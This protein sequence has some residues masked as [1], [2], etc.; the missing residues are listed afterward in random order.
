MNCRDFERWLD[1]GM[2]DG[3]AARQH[4]DACDSCRSKLSAAEA[5][6]AALA[7]GIPSGVA[8]PAG[9]T[10]AVM[11]RVANLEAAR[12]PQRFGVVRDAFPWWVRAAAEPSTAMALVLCALILWQSPAI[13]AGGVKLFGWL[14]GINAAPITGVFAKLDPQ[15]APILA[16]A[17]GLALLPAAAWLAFVAFRWSNRVVA[18]ATTPH[19]HRGLAS[20]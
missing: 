11:Q 16:L 9:F 7:H 4:S 6:E 14:S 12:T 3:T 5:M 20:H 15:N 2:P 19:V 17:F 10:D 18:Q 8:A 13:L 1:E